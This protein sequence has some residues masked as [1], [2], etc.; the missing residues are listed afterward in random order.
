MVT[1]KSSKDSINSMATQ[2]HE[3][4]IQKYLRDPQNSLDT[5]KRDFFFKVTQHET[6]P[7]LYLI[8]YNQLESPPAHPLTLECRGIILDAAKNWEVVSMA[9]KRFANY[10]ESWAAPIDW[11]TA[12]VEEKLDGSKLVMYWYNGGWQV[13]TS[14]MPDAK[15]PVGDLL[16]M[17]FRELFWE[18]FTELRLP[19]PPDPNCT[20]VFELCTP[21]NR[22][23]IKHESS[24]L[25]LIGVRNRLTFEEQNTENY[26]H[27]YPIAKRF[28]LTDIDSVL[29]AASAIDPSKDEGF[30][31]VDAQWNRVKVKSEQFVALHNMK[32]HMSYKRVLEVIRGNESS[33]V[34]S[35]FP[36]YKP[37]FDDV[38]KKYDQLVY[39][40]TSF[41]DQFKYIPEQKTFA[42]QAKNSRLPDALFCVRRGEFSS[43]KEYLSKARLDTVANV[44]RLKEKPQIEE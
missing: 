32:D 7:N 13:S 22:G 31:V 8:K 21:Y 28:T 9:F 19:L 29:Q 12:R 34:L 5:L 1:A 11:S 30:V 23:V 36:E 40:L 41:Y 43:F 16:T 14:G 42:L 44:L 17:P 39:D 35:Y 10:G 15:G 3:L 33:E 38:Q 24:S 37:I 6:Y 18:V 26:K 2:T 20:W 27:L 4:E 25:T